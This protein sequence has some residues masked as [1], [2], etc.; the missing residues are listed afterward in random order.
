MTA[1]L[2]PFQLRLSGAIWIDTNTLVG[3]NNLPDRLP[4]DASITYSSLFNLLN[5]PIGGRS[6]TFLPQYG[7][8]LYQILQEPLDAGTTSLIQ[9]GF[10]Q[11]IE[12]WEPRIQVDYANTTVNI[13]YTI[14]GYRVQLAYTVNL[15]QA[16][17]SQTFVLA[18]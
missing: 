5:C 11:A 15:T 7:S 4:D 14:P 17:G 6:R 10:I 2:T 13:D 16:R 18:Q 1:A 8:V 9:L 3:L 12:Q